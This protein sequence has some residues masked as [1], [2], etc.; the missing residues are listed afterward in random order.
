MRVAAGRVVLCDNRAA[1]GSTARNV[2]LRHMTEALRNVDAEVTQAEG[3]V[4]A[5][6]LA[7]AAKAREPRLGLKARRRLRQ[8][9]AGA[10]RLSHS[11]FTHCFW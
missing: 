6:D 4:T 2:F 1:P 8:R 11:S 5:L 7:A 3:P 9:E 10:A